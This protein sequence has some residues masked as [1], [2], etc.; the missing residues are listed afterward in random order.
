MNTEVM[1][2]QY[3]VLSSG[4]VIMPKD[5]FLLSIRISSSVWIKF[6][7]IEA[8]DDADARLSSTGDDGLV[9][10]QVRYLPT[11]LGFGSTTKYTEI[12][13]M[14]G[15]SMSMS[16]MIFANVDGSKI[17]DYTIVSKEM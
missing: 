15:K 4:R 10:V 3:T 9:F 2:G 11:V 8:K 17:F 5:E 16:F 6:S 7:I 12:A 13:S 1:V 14:D